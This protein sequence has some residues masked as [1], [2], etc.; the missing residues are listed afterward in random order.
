MIAVVGGSLDP[1]GPA[2]QS[3]ADLWWL[4]LALGTIPLVIVLGL[5]AYGLFRPRP[6]DPEATALPVPPEDET[7]PDPSAPEPVPDTTPTYGR[8]LIGGGVLMPTALIAIT[9]GAT[10]ESMNDVPTEG[11][12]DALVVE[13]TGHQ[14]WWEIRYPDH[15]ITT[16][17]ELHVPVDREVELQLRSEDVI[18]SFWVPELAGKLDLLP[19]RTNTLVLEASA[20]GTYGGACAEFCGL[21]HTNMELT[22]VASDE[23]DFA[24]W[25]AAQQEP[26][27]G[28]AD[29]DPSEGLEVFLDEGCATCHTIRGTSAAGDDGPDLTHVAG[30]DRLAAGAIANTAEDLA[31]WI[32]D[33]HDAKS[34]VDMPASDLTDDE[35]DAV[36]AYLGSLE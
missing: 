5:L 16:A 35:I 28:A 27:A 32:A 24:A 22:V 23:A 11:S 10:I 36:V 17:N 9:L 1:Q 29:A 12:D 7:D 21:A 13:V 6:P 20:P 33:P 31:A 25:V 3:I 8:W 18:H 30:R 2:A 26:A 4:L 15:A 14:W 19:E 34:G